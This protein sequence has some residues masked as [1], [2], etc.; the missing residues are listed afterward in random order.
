MAKNEELAAYLMTQ[1]DDSH[2]RMVTLMSERLRE[3]DEYQLEKYLGALGNFLAKLEDRDK[4][5]KRIGKE[6]IAET[7]ALIMSELVD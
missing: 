4:D 2:I 3:A 6:M 1:I 5:L 7:A